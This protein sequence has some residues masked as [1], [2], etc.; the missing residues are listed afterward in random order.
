[1]VS[2]AYGFTHIYDSW[3][4]R[5]TIKQYLLKK[6]KD[7]QPN[8]L[9]LARSLEKQQNVPFILPQEA[10]LEET[11]RAP[12]GELHQRPPSFLWLAFHA[13]I[14][15]IAVAAKNRGA[16]VFQPIRLLNENHG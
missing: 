8:G 15:S 4:S 13:I 14:S 5:G 12:L 9:R 10:G 1:M 11:Y 7:N 16:A 3:I 2:G 6:Q